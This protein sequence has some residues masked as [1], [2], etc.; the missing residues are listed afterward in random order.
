MRERPNR[1]VSKTVVGT[2]HRGFESHSLRQVI[3][4]LADETYQDAGRIL[5]GLAGTRRTV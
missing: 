5:F 1:T 3:G 2:A 4:K